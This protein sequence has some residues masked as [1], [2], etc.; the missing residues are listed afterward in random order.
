MQILET[1]PNAFK[2]NL[3]SYKKQQIPLLFFACHKW[4]ESRFKSSF[5]IFFK[6]VYLKN[7]HKNG[8]NF[9]RC[10][11]VLNSLEISNIEY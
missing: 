10:S 5:K 4:V 7:R 2:I 6:A 9:V 3:K 8:S 11:I 1:V